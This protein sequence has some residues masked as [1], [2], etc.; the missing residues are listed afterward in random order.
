MRVQLIKPFASNTQVDEND[1]F[2]MK[3]VLNRL[4]YY[5]PAA[6][7]GITNIVDRNVFQGL[8]KFQKDN[9]LM[10]SGEARPGDETER[11]LNK[12][13]DKR[14][15]SECYIWHT[16]KDD[17]VRPSHAAREGKI[18]CW[19]S[20]PDDGHPGEDFNCRCWAEPL[21]PGVRPVYPELLLI[22]ALRG[23]GR[24]LKIIERL[25]PNERKSNFTTHGGVRSNQRNITSSEIEEAI[26][27][28]KENS[29]VAK[30]TGKYGTP[31]DHYVGSNGVTVVVETEGRNAGKV[32]TVWRH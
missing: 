3:R 17:K 14:A 15:E 20:P 19:D 8:K 1:V 5:K 26:R 9:G 10:A 21:E 13:Q 18:F 29:N 7:T 25:L 24:I 16:A 31:Q 28:A 30:K 27:T 22:P 4:G 12:A 2:Q 11:M 23:I 32:I 6:D